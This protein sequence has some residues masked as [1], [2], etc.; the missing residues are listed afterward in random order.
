[1]K[2]GTHMACSVPISDDHSQEWSLQNL[3]VF[4]IQELELVMMWRGA[5][6]LVL[7]HS[8]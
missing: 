3:H 6:S 8:S 7:E 4:L 2:V 1:M 5:S